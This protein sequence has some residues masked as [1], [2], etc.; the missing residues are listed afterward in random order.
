MLAHVTVSANEKAVLSEE[1]NDLREKAPNR[2]WR[3]CDS[4]QSA[5]LKG[6]L[7]FH[8]THAI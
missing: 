8:D 4:W 2:W 1:W 6:I 7:A 5:D 3:G